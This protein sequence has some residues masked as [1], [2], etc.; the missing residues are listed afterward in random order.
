M[1]QT[2]NNVYNNNNNHQS[3][4]NEDAIIIDCVLAMSDNNV[5]NLYRTIASILPQYNTHQ[6][7]YRVRNLIN[8][9][10]TKNL[11][12]IGLKKIGRKVAGYRGQ[13]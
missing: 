4:N 1:V 7:R 2:R 11:S 8:P 10:S 9:L 5:R 12:T 13:G 3:G 6:I